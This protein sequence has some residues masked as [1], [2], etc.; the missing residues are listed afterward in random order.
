VVLLLGVIQKALLVSLPSRA[1]RSRPF[2]S[3][4]LPSTF[5]PEPRPAVMPLR[6]MA[7]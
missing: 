6:R 3:P 1:M 4:W 7:G 5:E 2:E